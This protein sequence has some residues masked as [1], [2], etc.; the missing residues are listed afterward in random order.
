MI[1]GSIVGTPVHM[2]PEMFDKRSR[3]EIFDKCSHVSVDI[4]A[5][6]ILFW[7]ICSGGVQL[8]KNYQYCANKEEL[9]TSVRSGRR[10][11]RLPQFDDNCWHLMQTCW[12]EDVAERPHIGV[13]ATYIDKL[14]HERTTSMHR[15]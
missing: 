5:F 11:E 9:W 14:M 2:C 8:P 12:Q 4:Y 13:I 6:G 15:H 1:T 7:Y 3:V 10:P